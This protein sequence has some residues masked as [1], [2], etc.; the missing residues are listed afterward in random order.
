MLHY[1][2]CIYFVKH[3]LLGTRVAE[4]KNIVTHG[5]YNLQKWNAPY[6]NRIPDVVT[7]RQ[8]TNAGKFMGLERQE[9]E[10]Q[11]NDSKPCVLQI[12]QI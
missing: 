8:I 12:Y 6:R 5:C 11:L 9:K 3:L 7:S 4:P 2:I 1:S 10:K